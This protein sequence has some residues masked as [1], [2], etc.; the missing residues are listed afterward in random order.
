[1]EFC[2]SRGIKLHIVPS[3]SPW[4]T[5]VGGRDEQDLVRKVV[6]PGP[7][8]GWIQRDGRAGQMADSQAIQTYPSALEV[9]AKRTAPGAGCEHPFDSN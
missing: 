5:G 4:I 8:Q 2:E 7:G 1:M 6:R 9:L 3:H